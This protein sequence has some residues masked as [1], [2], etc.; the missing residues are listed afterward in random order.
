MLGRNGFIA[1]VRLPQIPYLSGDLD[2]A[3]PGSGRV[4]EP[5]EKFFVNDWQDVALGAATVQARQDGSG[6]GQVL[7]FIVFK[8]D[9][10]GIVAKKQ[11]RRRFK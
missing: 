1:P 2:V 11:S 7:I 8:G 9:A 4:A 6:F 5:V 10:D 3:F